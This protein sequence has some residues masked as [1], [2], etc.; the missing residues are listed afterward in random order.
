M[1]H[2]FIDPLGQYFLSAKRLN[3]SGSETSVVGEKKK[4]RKTS[5]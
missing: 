3:T 5:F 4:S 2:S 1:Y